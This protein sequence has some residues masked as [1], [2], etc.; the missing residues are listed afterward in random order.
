MK[1]LKSATALFLALLCLFSFGGCKSDSKTASGSSSGLTSSHS[2]LVVDDSK[3]EDIY[4]QEEQHSGLETSSASDV[5]KPSGATD[6]SSVSS[7]SSN[8]QQ[9]GN[10]S[11]DE[12]SVTKATDYAGAQ[13]VHAYEAGKETMT[14][15][16][17]VSPTGSDSGNGSLKNPFKTIKRAQEAVRSYLSSNKVPAGGIAVWLRAG[18]YQL[19][20]S[21]NFTAA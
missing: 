2:G 21:L 4:S 11:G 9:P 6:N 13:A 19:S 17:Y 14:L 20:D 3:P 1:K 7:S 12:N 15:G 10:G 5:K 18:T 16:Y 8:Q